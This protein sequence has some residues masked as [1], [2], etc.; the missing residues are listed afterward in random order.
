MSHLKELRS[1]SGSSQRFR[2]PGLSAAEN[3]ETLVIN[4]SV[5]LASWMR[6][7]GWS[8][9]LAKSGARSKSM[10]TTESCISNM[11]L[12]WEGHVHLHVLAILSTWSL[13][14]NIEAHHRS[15]SLWEWKL[16]WNF[17]S[18]SMSRQYAGHLQQVSPTIVMQKALLVLPY[19]HNIQ[20]FNVI[21]PCWQQHSDL[22]SGALI[23]C[24]NRWPNS[25]ILSGLRLLIMGSP[26]SNSTGPGTTELLGLSA[27]TR[28]ALDISSLKICQNSLA[29]CCL[30]FASN[31]M[32]AIKAGETHLHGLS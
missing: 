8:C 16:T 5:L 2:E 6:A 24:H 4:A 27:C 13:V 15:H 32:S 21:Q 11:G 25:Q 28:I 17:T 31:A 30:A 20:T 10:P 14:S 26:Q 3:I 29:K 9:H 18:Y 1:S 23:C 22:F 12:S 7:T 19:R